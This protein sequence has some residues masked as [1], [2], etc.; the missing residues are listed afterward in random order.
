MVFCSGTVM[1]TS[2]IKRLDYLTWHTYLFPG[3]YPSMIK[4]V[5]DSLRRILKK[6]QLNINLLVIV[7]EM[8]S[9]RAVLLLKILVICRVQLKRKQQ[10]HHLPLLCRIIMKKKS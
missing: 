8:G 6:Y 4:G 2:H 10:W 1:D 3:D 9:G 7:D 5:A